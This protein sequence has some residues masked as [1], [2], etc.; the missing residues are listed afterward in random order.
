MFGWDDLVAQVAR[1]YA[2]LTPEERAHAVVFGQNYGEAG[3][4]DVLGR[5]LGLPRAISGHN[6]YYLWGPGSWDGQVLIII[7]GD[8][9]DNAAWF[10]SLEKVGTWDHPYAMPYERGRGIYIGRGFK[11]PPRE[12]WPKLKHFI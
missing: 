7:G 1:A 5:K 2:M 8:E 3:A 9:A 6:N 4:V 11:F 10:R 12:A